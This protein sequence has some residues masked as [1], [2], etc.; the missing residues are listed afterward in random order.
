M[1]LLFLPQMEKSGMELSEVKADDHHKSSNLLLD[2]SLGFNL[3]TSSSTSSEASTIAKPADFPSKIFA[4]NYCQRKFYSSQAL[5]G[6][7][8]AHKRERMIAKRP[9]E[10]AS[11]LPRLYSFSS[12][13]S[14]PQS[15]PIKIHSVS[16]LH[17]LSERRSRLNCGLN[18]IETPANPND[19]INE[20]IWHGNF[21]K[22]P[23]VGNS[24]INPAASAS[25]AP[26][27]PCFVS[28]EPDLTLRL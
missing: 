17:D 3:E 20:M 21:I 5:G 24:L 2:L 25:P 9:V 16:R 10:T 18:F 22:Q 12:S 7:Q 13:S 8:N 23:L 1:C 26:D 6:H 11:T 15:L 19:G 27:I 28:D 4:C 14:S